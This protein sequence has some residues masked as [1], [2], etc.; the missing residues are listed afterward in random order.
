MGNGIETE[1][2]YPYTARDGSC[3]ANSNNF[4]AHNS[5]SKRVS[6]SESSLQS[7]LAT[8]GYDK[9]SGSGYWIVKNSW[10]GSWGSSGYIKMKIGENSCGIS[11]NPMYALP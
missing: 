6:H 1:Q 5:G 2:T 3:H 4:V 11:N 8:V 7:A 10:G 9:T